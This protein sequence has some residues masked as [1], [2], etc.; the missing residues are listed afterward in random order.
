M[1][2]VSST[3]V[4]PG[5]SHIDSSNTPACVRQP[6]EKLQQE[7]KSS[8]NEKKKETKASLCNNYDDEIN[9]TGEKE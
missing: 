3:I 9:Q 1:A 4:G 7:T 5:W 8:K 2:C 6:L